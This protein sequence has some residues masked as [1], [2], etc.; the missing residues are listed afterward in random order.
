[1]KK[2]FY[3]LFI[4][5]AMS[6]SALSGCSSQSTENTAESAETTTLSATSMK[7]WSFDDEDI[8]KVTKADTVITLN[9][10]NADINGNGAELKDG[11]IVISSSGV[12]ELTGNFSGSITVS[13]D[14]DA[15]IQLLL[16]NVDITSTDGPA[17]YVEQCGKAVV[18][19]VENSV[20]SLIDSS[21]YKLS[22]GE[23]EPDAALFS[24]DD[25]V[26]NGAGTFNITANYNDGIKGKDNL[27]ITGG[28][29]NVTAVDDGIIGRDI[30][31]V[32][33]A[34][35]NVESGGD[36][37]KTTNSDESE[38]GELYIEG[39]T[40]K[41]NA[42]GDGMDSANAIYFN[43]GDVT[44]NTG[45]GAESV[46]KK[47]TGEFKRND[48]FDMDSETDDTEI[49]DTASSQKGIKAE[50]IVSVSGG[51]L[52]TD[53]VDDSIH[54]NDAAYISGGDITISSGD[55][56]V[57]ADNSLEISGGSINILTSYEGLEGFTVTISDGDISLYAQDDGINA[58]GG[59]SDTDEA[60]SSD[61]KGGAM[62]ETSGCNI[63]ISG[64]N[65]YV[66]ADGD[67][68]DSNDSISMTGG[69]LIANG[70]TNN[71]NG[72]F[73]FD[74]SMIY[75]GG[76]L[77][78]SGSSGML[79]TPDSSSKVSCIVML[80]SSSRS[81]G[82]GVVLTTSD[83]EIIA[84]VAP[85]KEYTTITIGSDKIESGKEY[86]LVYGAELS[87][88]SENGIYSS[89]EIGSSVGEVTFTVSETVTY[90]D[91]NGITDKSSVGGMQGGKMG[92]EGM[93]PS[94][95][96]PTDGEEPPQNMPQNDD[97]TGAA[98]DEA[99]AKE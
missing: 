47:Y 14:K 87:G 63:T 94:G 84:A 8:Y 93:A 90:V 57:H 28:T 77:I 15:E 20:N 44:V 64:G 26:I 65:I 83:G 49:G 95:E 2:H 40:I 11:N 6:I 76:T 37:L 17:I 99:P 13:S 69:T 10:T 7:S 89:Y 45:E 48:T 18:S 86:K 81:A 61:N 82:N 60:S 54:S 51:K 88:E 58:A 80:F 43:S 4:A 25:M 56:G 35:I 29:I 66:N 85:N 34:N 92:S 33:D 31:A 9:G 19:T 38:K 78:A 36:A 55:D 98:S 70:P 62:G 50:N 24:K 21:E 12:Y 52:V 23:D 68:I 53:T 79:Q 75:D 73:D 74:S 5:V 42:D 39:G 32:T 30:L 97:G 46:T 16:N 67:G 91:E 41:L 59:S 96:K 71:G 22:D 1:M 72:T 3:I 27:I